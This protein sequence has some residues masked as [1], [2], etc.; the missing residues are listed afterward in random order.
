MPDVSYDDYKIIDPA[1]ISDDDYL[2]INDNSAGKLGFTKKI[3][4]LNL[5]SA[6]ASAIAASDFALDDLNNVDALSPSD[7]DVLAF[8]SGSGRWEPV[9]PSGGGGGASTLDGLTDVFAPAP[10]NGQVLAFVA[11]SSRWEPTSL[12]GGGA[13]TLNGLTDVNSP[14]PA[15]G[16]YL[17]WDSGTSQWIAATAP[18]GGSGLPTS[19]GTMTGQIIFGARTHSQITTFTHTQLIFES[20]NQV[21]MEAVVN[22]SG[23]S[24]QWS[25]TPRSNMFSLA[26]SDGGI[27]WWMNFFQSTTGFDVFE[28]HRPSAT[29]GLESDGT[30]AYLCQQPYD[31]GVGSWSGGAASNGGTGLR[32][33]G[34]GYGGSPEGTIVKNLH[35]ATN[36]QA[37]GMEFATCA[38]AL[39][40]RVKLRLLG[41][42]NTTTGDPDAD[43]VMIWVGGALRLITL[44]G[45]FLKCV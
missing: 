4:W 18:G 25:G 15:D 29:L 34:L 39:D 16:Q 12:P 6:L 30:L 19:G 5:R 43:G 33:S 44:D 1:D 35:I 9:A 38:K 23:I 11:G 13:T 36:Q 40:P 37:R 45:G 8:N 27:R 26:N 20:A 31:Y 41:D 42:G 22:L 28:T 21:N 2:L 10:T 17:K 7:G 32:I 3:S 24:S 14:T